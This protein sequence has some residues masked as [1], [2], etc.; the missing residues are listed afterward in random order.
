MRLVR[1][2]QES[3]ARR[4]FH[5]SGMPR[6]GVLERYQRLVPGGFGIFLRLHRLDDEAR[7][8]EVQD[9]SPPEFPCYML[10]VVRR[11]PPLSA[12]KQHVCDGASSKLGILR[13]LIFLSLKT[14]F[15]GTRKGLL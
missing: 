7:I 2:V 10:C 13:G 3:G 15:S 12:T 11:Q 5:V 1:A 8:R 9:F 6:M 4:R 14:A